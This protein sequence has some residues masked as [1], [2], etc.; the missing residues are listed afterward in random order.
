MHMAHKLFNERMA[1]V[2]DPP[3][4]NL[5]VRVAPQVTAAEMMKAARLTWK[6]DVKPA[7]GSK[8][9][10]RKGVYDRYLIT[11]EPVDDE[12]DEVVLG[13]VSSRYVPLQN[14]EAFAFFEP[15]IDNRWAEFH[16]AGALGNGERIWV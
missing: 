3:W 9:T 10:K 12:T 16:T 1:F 8:I 7:P 5:G 11:R 15:F 2:G 13:L 6:V 4:H 14:T